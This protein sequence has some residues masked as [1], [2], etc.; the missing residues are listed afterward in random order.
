MPE[1]I[2]NL[3]LLER[4]LQQMSTVI[5]AILLEQSGMPTPCAEWDVRE[6]VRHVT[7]KDLR[8]FAAAIRGETI[9]WQAPAGDLGPN[10]QAQ[11]D[12]ASMSLLEA[13]AG[14][15]PDEIVKLPTGGEGP[16]RARADQ[17]IAEMC[18][19][20][21][22]LVHA[23]GQQIDLD[24]EPAERALAWSKATLRPE[25][26]GPGKPF[27]EEVAVSEDAPAYDRLAGWFGRDPR[28]QAHQ[29]SGA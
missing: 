25:A 28:W 9:D 8:N 24:E 1:E 15:D 21:W 2:D 18:V 14:V 23:T 16:L 5:G 27:G 26:R 22:D 29:P 19:H 10:W 13:W 20:A 7:T 11:F 6:L 17:Q 12:E 4:S 3:D